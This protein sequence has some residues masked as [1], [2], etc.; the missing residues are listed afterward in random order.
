MSTIVINY[1]A[2]LVS[3]IASFVLGGLWYGPIF[4]KLWIKLSNWSEKDME[5]AK[6]KGMALPYF[7]TF[8]ASL[9]TAFV[10]AHFVY[11]TKAITWQNGMQTG[12]WIWLGFVATSTLGGVL[13]E[14]KSVRLYCLNNA[15]ELA[16][17][18]MIGVILAVW[19]A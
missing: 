18:M 3:G 12:F 2:V 9:L 8:L 7:M 19:V 1:W 6:K 13:W 4:G 17:F 16:K 10:M 5:A 15:Y 11:Y 14:G